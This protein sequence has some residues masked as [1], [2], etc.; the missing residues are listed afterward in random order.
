MYFIIPQSPKWVMNS[1]SVESKMVSFFFFKET[2][3]R[4][5]VC[6]YLKITSEQLPLGWSNILAALPGA[7]TFVMEAT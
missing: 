7:K 3:Y 1:Q 6:S 4:N 2:Q 5:S